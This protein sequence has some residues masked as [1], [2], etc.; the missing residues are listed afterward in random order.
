M[1]SVKLFRRR[2]ISKRRRRR[3]SLIQASSNNSKNGNSWSYWKIF[4]AMII[5][6]LE[7][8]NIKWRKLNQNKWWQ[9]IVWTDKKISS[10]ERTTRWI[11]YIYIYYSDW[12]NIKWRMHKQ[13]NDFLIAL[14]KET[15]GKN[16][17]KNVECVFQSTK[18]NPCSCVSRKNKTICM[19]V[20]KTN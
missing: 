16:T 7:G 10:E 20:S 1:A 4:P 11:I 13:M 6:C 2:R 5:Y 17:S 14:M 3:R 15:K 12:E 18:W 19:L 8:E 9:Y